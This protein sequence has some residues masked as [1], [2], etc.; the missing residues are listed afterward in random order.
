MDDLAALLTGM[1][2]T[3]VWR[4]SFALR[5]HALR[6][7]DGS[8]FFVD[9]H[10]QASWGDVLAWWR[11]LGGACLSCWAFQH[12]TSQSPAAPNLANE[13]PRCLPTSADGGAAAGV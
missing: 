5:E 11:L 12:F 6:L 4:T 7:P 9:G 2:S 13:R 10:F 1:A 8:R 3:V